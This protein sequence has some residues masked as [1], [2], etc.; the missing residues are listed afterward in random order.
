M[1]R[2][3]ILGGGMAGF[4]I[5][6]GLEK[7]LKPGQAQVTLV[8]IRTH[9]IY[10]PFLAEVASGCIESR[11]VQVA[12]RSHLRKTNIVQAKVKV[13]DRH[14]KTVTVSNEGE[15]WQ[16]PYDQVI[17]CLGAVTKTFPTP[18]VAD[19]A[20]GLKTTEEAVWIRNKIIENFSI[21][22]SLP[23]DSPR[24]KRLLT[25]VV[26]GGG[27]SGIEG[28]S[29]MLD[30]T[31]VL[32]KTHPGIAKEEVEL[33]LIEATDHIMPEMPLK[34][35]KWVIEQLE[36]RGA[37]IH[38]STFC[39]D[40]TD[41][42]V[43]LSSGEEIPTDVLVW[44]AG[45]VACPVMAD[46]DLPLEPRGRLTVDTKLRVVDGEE[47]LPGMWGCGDATCCKD[48][49]GGGLPDESCAPTAQHAVRQARVLVKNIVASL[50]GQAP[51]DYC[52]KNA[53]CV[54]GL[55]AWLG[56]FASGQKKLIVRGPFAWCMH[57]GYHGFAMP[58]WERKLRIFGDWTGGLIL[59]K[60]VSSTPETMRPKAFFEKFA[61]RPAE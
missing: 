57:R 15:T 60:D 34:D 35:S 22:Q 9:M 5:A 32:L 13:I 49:S 2:I 46:S 44:T 8:D 29:E 33:H 25:Y 16:I 39:N 31:R 27:F 11:H 14:N 40:A 1:E 28:F 30:L 47:V 17:I 6:K 61:K 53:G 48:L 52:H 51:L 43:K 24:R 41:G 19:Q 20:I 18:G 42:I 12:L 36:K 23:T 50:E 59:G 26:V 4:Y 10:Q 54:A 38:L 7:S 37:R 3:L 58:T 56:I 55:G 21:A 45:V